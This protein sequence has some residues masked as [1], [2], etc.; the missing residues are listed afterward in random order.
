MYSQES[1]PEGR[2]RIVFLTVR[3]RKNNLILAQVSAT[4]TEQHPRFIPYYSAPLFPTIIADHGSLHY[5]L[6]PAST[7][8]VICV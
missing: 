4:S 7:A 3:C 8:Y 5:D 2:G 1:L 6:S